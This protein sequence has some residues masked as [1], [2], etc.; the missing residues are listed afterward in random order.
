M[1]KLRKGT[2]IKF[3]ESGLKYEVTKVFDGEIYDIKALQP[4]FEWMADFYPDYFSIKLQD[5]KV[6]ANAQN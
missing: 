4:L 1:S 3:T 5:Y 2:K 6:I